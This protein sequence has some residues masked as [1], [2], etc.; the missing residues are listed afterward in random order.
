MLST[1]T[2]PVECVH[3]HNAINSQRYD[4]AWVSPEFNA[5]LPYGEI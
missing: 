1:T 2:H 5:L 4:P 3:I